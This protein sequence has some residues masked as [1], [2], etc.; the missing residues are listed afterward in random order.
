MIY[1]AAADDVDAPMPLF[2]LKRA[3]MKMP[4]ERFVFIYDA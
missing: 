4:C 1:I 3:A 2:S